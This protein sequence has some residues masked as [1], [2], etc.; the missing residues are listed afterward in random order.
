MAREH[1]RIR[2]KV[3]DLPETSVILDATS[4]PPFDATLL[5]G[6]AAIIFVIDV[7]DDYVD[8]LTKLCALALRES[9]SGQTVPI[10]VLLHKTDCMEEAERQGMGRT[11][12]VPFIV[13]T[14]SGTLRKKSPRRSQS[15]ARRRPPSAS[16]SPASTTT[17][18]LSA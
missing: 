17:P 4:A 2:L 13:E 1:R 7:T 10:E 16:T 8:A 9:R 5:D 15:C 14:F 6:C 18:S 11:A 12:A 3:V